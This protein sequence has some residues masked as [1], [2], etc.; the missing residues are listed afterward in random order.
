MSR[1]DSDAAWERLAH[2]AGLAFWLAQLAACAP[3]P[4][5]GSAPPDSHRAAP[6]AT[7]EVPRAAP[8]DRE[9]SV[10]DAGLG[11]ERVPESALGCGVACR[12]ELGAESVGAVTR[13]S[14]AVKR[15][16]QR[17]LRSDPNAKGRIQV[18]LAI[19][20]DGT[21]CRAQIV[22]ADFDDPE[23]ASCVLESMRR[24]RVV[25]EHGCVVIRVPFLF[26]PPSSAG[27]DGG[28]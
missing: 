1:R 6:I 13:Q 23:L 20:E 22:R 15:C 24:V 12:G 26:V 4:V 3:K 21:V 17:R 28:P 5:P 9:E 10:T 8:D 18:E 11:V 27:V 25:P 16:Y 19:E 7:I 14:Q 2:R